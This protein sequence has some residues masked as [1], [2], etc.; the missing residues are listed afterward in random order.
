MPRLVPYHF[1]TVTTL[2]STSLPGHL[3]AT[4]APFSPPFAALQGHSRRDFYRFY[5]RYLQPPFFHPYFPPRE[6]DKS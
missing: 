6:H 5:N 4:P 1:F 2:F 3:G